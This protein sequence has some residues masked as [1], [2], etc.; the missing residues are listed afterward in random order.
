ML[1]Y[2]FYG[3]TVEIKILHDSSILEQHI[4]QAYKEFRHMQDS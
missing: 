1:M 2:S 3:R 4:S